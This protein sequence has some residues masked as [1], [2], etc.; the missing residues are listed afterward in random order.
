MG[1]A[2]FYIRR[3][4]RLGDRLAGWSGS[5]DSCNNDPGSFTKP[6]GVALSRNAA[7]LIVLALVGLAFATRVSTGTPT[8]PA[9]Q[10]IVPVSIPE[11]SPLAVRY[12]H[13]GNA[14]WVVSTLWGFAVPA[15]IFF[16]GLSARL[17]NASKRVP[18]H[19]YLALM[20]YFGL[21]ALIYFAANL[22]LDYYSDFSRPHEFGLSSQTFGKWLHDEWL[23]VGLDFIGGALV[24]WIP[25]LLLKH[26]AQRWWLYTWFA[27]VP[28]LF[29]LAFV[30][31][32]WIEPLFNHF[33]PMQDQALQSRLVD[34]AH[35][36]GIDGADVYQVN[37]SVDT[38]QLNAYVAG[39][40]GSKRIVL[41]DT[42]LK[43]FTPDEVAATMA[44]EMGHYALGHAWKALLFQSVA[45]LAGLW[46]IH[47]SAA[48]ILRRF[49]ART[50]VTELADIAALP[51]LILVFSV[52]VFV[53]TPPLLGVSRHFEHEADRFALELTHDNHTCAMIFVKFITH[54][55]AYPTPSRLVQVLRASHPSPGE[56][57]SFCNSYHPWLEVG[58]GV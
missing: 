29:C 5:R 49:S 25:F 39:I 56:R 12:Y 9:A 31:P 58:P 4:R 13:G 6:T 57:I 20:I 1:G 52:F 51:L 14:L 17:R 28:V 23:N 19:W 35:R 34:L 42:T 8:Q 24:L 36:A 32:I 26:A 22:P 21:F 3:F 44:H 48:R 11:P 40:G 45:L 16:T 15:L 47:L 33:G 50:G 38:N 18:G 10:V 7:V 55:L 27:G 43:A 41:W 37:K 53:M 54:D 46:L 2:F 30:E